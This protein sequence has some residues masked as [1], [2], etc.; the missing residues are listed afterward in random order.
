MITTLIKELSCSNSV[1]LDPIIF[2]VNHLLLVKC[3]SMEIYEISLDEKLLFLSRH[4]FNDT[5]LDIKYMQDLYFILSFPNYHYSTIRYD[6]LL[7]DF[8]TC[9]LHAYDNIL[10]AEG[11]SSPL[12][13]PLIKSTPLMEEVKGKNCKNS[14]I[15][16]FDSSTN[17]SILKFDETAASFHHHSSPSLSNRGNNLD[18]REDLNKSKIKT[19]KNK[20]T[21][22]TPITTR[23]SETIQNKER[24]REK[25][26]SKKIKESTSNLGNSDLFH[27]NSNHELLLLDDTNQGRKLSLL[28]IGDYYISI[29]D[30][31]T[32]SSTVL[33][34]TSIDSRLKNIHYFTFLHGFHEPTLAILFEHKPTSMTMIEVSKDSKE[35]LFISFSSS[36][37]NKKRLEGERE[38]NKERE[39][40]KD[41]I[42]SKNASFSSSS[43][44][45]FVPIAHF[46]N[47]PFDLHTLVP[48]RKGGILAI[49]QNELVFIDQ[50]ISPYTLALNSYTGRMLG[51]GTNL[52]MPSIENMA[53]TMKYGKAIEYI[54]N[55][56]S[57]M[58]TS[59]NTLTNTTFVINSLLFLK[60]DDNFLWKC[61]V[62]PKSR[63]KLILQKESLSSLMMIND[64]RERIDSSIS[65]LKYTLSSNYMILIDSDNNLDL[66]KIEK[67]RGKDDFKRNENKMEN[68]ESNENL[69]FKEREKDKNDEDD[70]SFLRDEEEGENY[71]YSSLFINCLYSRHL[72]LN[73]IKD[74]TF[75]R[76]Y[77]LTGATENGMIVEWQTNKG[78][79]LDFILSSF[80]IKGVCSAHIQDDYIFINSNH[81]QT[82]VLK[83]EKK[84]EISNKNQDGN[85][86]LKVDE[87]KRDANKNVNGNMNQ[88]LDGSK[89]RIFNSFNSS[90]HSSNLDPSNFQ[91]NE[92]MTLGG[93]ITILVDILKS[94]NRIIQ[95]YNMG[96]RILNRENLDISYQWNHDGI[97]IDAQILSPY[98]DDSFIQLE[99]RNNFNINIGELLFLLSNNEILQII[100]LENMKIIKTIPGIKSFWTLSSHKGNSFAILRNEMKLLEIYNFPLDH[101]FHSNIDNQIKNEKM[102]DENGNSNQNEI[103]NENSNKINRNDVDFINDPVLIF[104]ANGDIFNFPK[105]LTFDEKRLEKCEMENNRNKNNRNNVSFN[106]TIK[107]FP[108]DPFK[109]QSHSNSS[110][111]L[112]IFI[113][114]N[115]IFLCDG[116]EI[117][118]YRIINLNT[119][120]KVD[121]NVAFQP[122]SIISSLSRSSQSSL[123]LPSSASQSSSLNSQNRIETRGNREGMGIGNSINI[124]RNKFSKLMND[125]VIFHSSG[126]IIYMTRGKRHDCTELKSENQN[127]DN[128]DNIMT[129][130]INTVGMDN[131]NADNGN[132]NNMENDNFNGSEII[133]RIHP[134]E[135][136][137]ILSCNGNLNHLIITIDINDIVKIGKISPLDQLI[138]DSDIPYKKI[139]NF[140]GENNSISHLAY[141]PP[142]NSIITS[143]RKRI[144][145]ELP[146]DD[147][148]DISDN[149]EWKIPM[150]GPRIIPFDYSFTIALLSNESRSGSGN[151]NNLQNDYK[152]EN[153]QNENIEMK[154]ENE[155]IID[156]I[157][158]DPY[159]HLTALQLII[160]RSRQHSDKQIIVIGTAYLKGEDRPVKGRLLVLDVVTIVPDPSRPQLDRKFRVITIQETKGPVSALGTL[161]GHLVTAI[162]SKTLVHALDEEDESIGAIAFVDSG[163]WTLSIASIKSFMVLGDIVK[164]ISFYAFQELP[165]KIQLLSKDIQEEMMTMALEFITLESEMMIIGADKL[166]NLILLA[167]SPVNPNSNGGSHLISK[168]AIRISSGSPIKF[169]RYPIISDLSSLNSSDS[170]D[171][172]VS[173]S[174]NNSTSRQALLYVTREGSIGTISPLSFSDSLFDL[175]SKLVSLLPH[176]A[177]LNPR[178]SREP[179]TNCKRL[180]TRA[181]IDG[182]LLWKVYE[183]T[184]KARDVVGYQGQ[185]ESLVYDFL[186]QN[187][188]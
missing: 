96:F 125:N 117:V 50:G 182:D 40:E 48:L 116:I 167:Y 58:N 110:L 175:Q 38:R 25:E 137:Q 35:V 30:W 68:G 9:S 155:M 59:T 106:D 77:N 47:L 46:T 31:N 67:K 15:I 154:N 186:L 104:Q 82:V 174:L 115:Y 150:T 53:I 5:I 54:D 65:I 34:W 177:G 107:N 6:Y 90:S 17:A 120:V 130:T 108:L 81:S 56:S 39:K 148:S 109:S 24:E 12:I 164:G 42:S 165:S 64:Q 52:T 29:L 119:A 57:I 118:I 124:N 45:S 171:I 100:S 1:T 74:V 84:M 146:R 88:N 139:A 149:P 33:P 75:G 112:S 147:Y 145:F 178:S 21:P 36:S 113:K 70:L 49:G 188:K 80:N 161:N 92:L 138:L 152:M 123:S 157:E 19:S 85:S 98:H 16:S 121:W 83:L 163:I 156:K 180:P 18:S 144:E 89:S 44:G 135:A 183:L 166:G 173:G 160:L 23:T 71:H 73:G 63:N 181:I 168:G 14:T 72:G 66:C 60:D 27:Q 78:I 102:I 172:S 41:K 69:K 136:G 140:K 91:I 187:I 76:N 129:S 176:L 79:Q 20:N 111:G 86:I 62:N 3:N 11:S 159:E 170:G 95:I 7:L 122:L 169:L 105:F 127:I 142:T 37:L 99:N 97:I 158:L 32:R 134:F 162:G 133:P 179:L 185:C 13:T 93:G 43:P 151:G 184:R 55:H 51:G 4:K 22:T 131:I 153:I 101:S 143:L 114:D 126:R 26:K 61:I 10:Q 8:L 103:N 128:I 2:D 94:K 132:D 141:H 87:K 28:S